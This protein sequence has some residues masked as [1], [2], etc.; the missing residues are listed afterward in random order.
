M[1]QTHENALRAIRKATGKTQAQVA[2]DLGV[3]KATYS[4]WETGRH[5]MN[6]TQIIHVSE[7][8]ECSTNDVLGI[9]ATH[10]TYAIL[11]ES[12]QDLVHLFRASSPDIR[13]SIFTILRASTKKSRLNSRSRIS[14]RP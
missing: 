8:Y 9:E 11:T 7:Y 2:S 6:A 12:E 13:E 3:S 1:K 14:E 4:A 10:G 5:V